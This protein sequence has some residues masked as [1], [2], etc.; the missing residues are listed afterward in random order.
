MLVG[1]KGQNHPQ[2]TGRRGARPEVDNLATTPE[3]FDPLHERFHFTIDVAALPHNA[4]LERYFTPE[5][6]GLTQP[7]R[8]ERVFCNSPY[9]NIEPWAQKA[10]TANAELVVMLLPANRTEQGWWQR[11]VEPY[12]RVGA[13]EVEFLSGRLRFIKHG[14]DRVE[15]NQRPPFGCCLV[16][17]PEPVCTCGSSE[18]DYFG[19]RDQLDDPNC[20]RHAAWSEEQK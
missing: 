13:V 14:H 18:P 8:G 9:S 20:P 2:Q 12:R 19:N 4:K 11:Q 16:I 7:W 6:D 1:F 17:W 3:V 15:P 10:H 5:Q